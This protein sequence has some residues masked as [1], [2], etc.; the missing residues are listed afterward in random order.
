[1]NNVGSWFAG[2]HPSFE[3]SASFAVFVVR[4]NA[5]T[6]ELLSAADAHVDVFFQSNIEMDLHFSEVVPDHFF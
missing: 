4:A 5:L 1:M 6:L 3:V 2:P